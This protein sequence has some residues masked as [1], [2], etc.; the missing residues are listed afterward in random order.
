M[1]LARQPLQATSKPHLRCEVAP[2]ERTETPAQ[3]E[4]AVPE[5][6]ARQWSARIAS[7]RRNMNKHCRAKTKAGKRCKAVATERGL[8]AFHADPQ[9][10]AHLGRLGGQKNRRYRLPLG[11]EQPRVPQSAKEVKEMLAEA[12]AGLHAG[13]LEP[14]V[15]SVMAHLGTSL[16]KAFE[17]VD[18]ERRIGAL[19][20]ANKQECEKKA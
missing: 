6:M 11:A 20:E 10:A 14:R 12:M 9:R 19:E 18:L 4:P 3:T 15:G 1:P 2:G 16:L 13:R 7:Q 17:V 5:G 8:C